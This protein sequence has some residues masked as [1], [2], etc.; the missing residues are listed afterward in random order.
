M[1]K[2]KWY[3]AVLFL[4]L[5]SAFTAFAIFKLQIQPEVLRIYKT[6]ESSAR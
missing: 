6:V 5:L 3:L 1:K 2:L 4:V